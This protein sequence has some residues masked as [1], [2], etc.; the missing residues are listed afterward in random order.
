MS[1]LFAMAHEKVST[2]QLFTTVTST[3]QLNTTISCTEQLYKTVTRMIYY[4]RNLKLYIYLKTFRFKDNGG[5]VIRKQLT[6]VNEV[7]N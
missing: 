3:Q 7:G 4:K 6:N 5:K 2:R 1:P